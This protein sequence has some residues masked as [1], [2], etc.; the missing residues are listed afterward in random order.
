MSGTPVA[1]R[2]LVTGA[3]GMVGTALMDTMLARGYDALGTDID[4]DGFDLSVYHDAQQIVKFVRPN[5]IIDC[6]CRTTG[7]KYSQEHHGDMFY[8]AA[9]V[10]MNIMRAAVEFG[11]K[12]VLLVSSSCVYNDFVEKSEEFGDYSFPESANEGYG[13]GK[14]V[15]EYAGLMYAKQ[16]GIEVIR[17][18]PGNIYGPSYKF[19]G[20]QDKHVIPALIDKFLS[21]NIVNVWGSGRQSRCFLYETDCAEMLIQLLENGTPGEVYNLDGEEVTIKALAE[22][23]ADLTGYTRTIVFDASGPEGPARKVQPTSKLYEV[24]DL[25]LV[26]FKDGLRR[27]VAA[28]KEKKQ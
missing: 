24:V 22:M 1:N 17:V 27:T 5:F 19:Q 26:P 7:I 13:W 18:R 20:D 23:I 14:R 16:Y 8:N 2:V 3:A 4:T 10:P 28:A 6:A 12:R 15:A 9:I 25:S 11:V 21:G